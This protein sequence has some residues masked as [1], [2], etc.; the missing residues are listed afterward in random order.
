MA[1]QLGRPRSQVFR[2]RILIVDDDE[3]VRHLLIR[4][5]APQGYLVDE[6]ASGEEAIELLAEHIPD[7]VLLDVHMPGRSGHEVLRRIRDTSETR[8]LPVVM[9]TGAATSKDKLQAIDAGVTDF[10][11]KPF[12]PEELTARV[13]ALVQLKL[14]TDSL[15]DAERVIV[16]LAKTIDAR[17]PYTASHSERVS[18]YAG[19]LGA[20]IGLQGT[21]LSAV[22]RGGLFHDLGKI[23]IRDGILLKPGR[24]TR[25][26]FAQIKR[27]PVEGRNL[28]QH[29]K[30]LAHALDVVYYHHERY[31]GS[32]YP[33]GIAGEGIPLTARVTNIADIFD[34]LTTARVYRG[35]LSREESLAIMAAEV[36]KGWWDGRLLDEFRA[37]LEK[38]PE[39]SLPAPQVPAEP[40]PQTEA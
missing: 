16:A 1:E 27:H 11:S 39:T 34:A 3:Q 13:R 7:L 37:V 28:I 30:T 12:S 14:V 26:E 5:L 40:G 6:A 18:L 32:G 20:R 17:D 31:D 19:L 33:E 24:L 2:P 10:I 38:L 36:A 15:E 23:A 8:L 21:E 35:A 9:L 4:L 25:E 29:M 22:Q